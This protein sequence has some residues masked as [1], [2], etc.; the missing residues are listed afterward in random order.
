MGG[1]LLCDTCHGSYELQPGELPA[2]FSEKCEC[3]GNLKFVEKLPDFTPDVKEIPISMM[4]PICGTKNP[5][6]TEFCVSCG[7]NLFMENE[8]SILKELKSKPRN[9]PKKPKNKT[10]N[11]NKS[12]SRGKN[13]L[14]IIILLTVI[15]ALALYVV[16]AYNEV[17]HNPPSSENVI[18]IQ[19]SPS[20]STSTNSESDYDSGY[21]EGYFNGV[22]EAYSGWEYD[23]SLSKNLRVSDSFRNGYKMGYYIG[24]NDIKLG[25]PLERPQTPGTA[26]LDPRNNEKIYH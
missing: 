26:I 22:N 9:P 7:N 1:Y 16:Y 5:E 8:D 2:D 14:M 21:D 6:E 12:K 25:R 4:C 18:N 19:S 3:G 17:L 10:L 11:K 23:N 20:T 13:K 24:Y 15:V